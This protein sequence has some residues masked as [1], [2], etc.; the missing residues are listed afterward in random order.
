MAISKPFHAGL[1]TERVSSEPGNFAQQGA[2]LYSVQL[3]RHVLHT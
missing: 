3:F 1:L 2:E